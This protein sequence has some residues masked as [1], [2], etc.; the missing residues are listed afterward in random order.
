MKTIDGSETFFP[1][2]QADN[3]RWTCG[4]SGKSALL[5]LVAWACEEQFSPTDQGSDAEEETHLGKLGKIPSGV[6][7]ADPDVA[8]RAFIAYVERKLR[9]TGFAGD[10]EH[11]LPG[12]GQQDVQ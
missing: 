8:P 5:T 4:S 7:V 2:C 1:T 6:E 11:D 3:S 12:K 10:G 9:Q